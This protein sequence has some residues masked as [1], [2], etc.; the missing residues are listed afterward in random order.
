MPKQRMHPFNVLLA[1]DEYAHLEAMARSVNVSKGALLRSL[2]QRAWMMTGRGVPTCAD[3]CNCYVPQMHA[4]RLMPIPPATPRQASP[5]T[6]DQ[7]DLP[8]EE[9]AA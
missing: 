2:V 5:P 6:A 8:G 9:S 1:G 3:G 7:T 4:A